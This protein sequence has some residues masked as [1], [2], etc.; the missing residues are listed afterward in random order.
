[1]DPNLDPNTINQFIKPALLLMGGAFVF[2][3]QVVWR[4]FLWAEV[5]P[6]IPKWAVPLAMLP[7]AF[8]LAWRESVINPA[9]PL[10]TRQLADDWL[11][12]GW[13]LLAIMLGGWLGTVIAFNSGS[14]EDRAVKSGKG[15]ALV[16]S[17]VGAFLLWAFLLSGA[18]PASAQPS[19][20]LRWDPAR[21]SMTVSGGGV[22]HGFGGEGK[23]VGSSFAGDV[24]LSWNLSRTLNAFLAQ[25]YEVASE[26]GKFKAGG[27]AQLDGTMPGDRFA[28]F[29]GAYWA[30]R[31]G[32]GADAFLYRES[33][34]LY[35]LGAWSVAETKSGRKWLAVAASGHYDPNNDV[36]SGRLFLRARPF[37]G[38]QVAVTPLGGPQ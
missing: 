33:W 23:P 3:F 37:G 1:M 22:V 7:T 21:L 31:F 13:F 18:S 35:L 15:G 32:P 24:A 27:D 26:V 16:A 9:N 17:F 6:T 29:M 38:K 2:T 36:K 10:V 20:P 14:G 25:E 34:E 30:K 5:L 28:L 8:L 4:V 11:I 12:Q 19:G